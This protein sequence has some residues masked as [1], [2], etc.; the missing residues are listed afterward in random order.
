[1]VAVKI[2][3]AGSLKTICYN[4]VKMTIHLQKVMIMLFSQQLA[5]IRKKRGYTQQALADKIGIH[6]TQ[7]KRYE[8]GAARPTLE[9]FRNIVLALN[10]SADTMLFD[11]DE[12]GPDE[13]LRLH[14]EAISK[15]DP[16]EKSVIKE[17]IEGMLIKHD[18]KRWAQPQEAHLQ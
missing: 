8:A 3:F 11:S 5:A 7:I 13:E 10:V 9:V 14:F 16:R 17:L 12:R 18:T 1:M 4:A 2:L 15:L 6:V